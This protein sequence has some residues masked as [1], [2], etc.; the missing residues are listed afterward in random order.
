MLTW[1]EVA[2][3]RS[4]PASLSCALSSGF[5]SGMAPTALRVHVAGLLV[6]VGKRVD[7]LRH[8]LRL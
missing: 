2:A 8:S 1:L 3:W 5:A 7:N 4:P 6:V